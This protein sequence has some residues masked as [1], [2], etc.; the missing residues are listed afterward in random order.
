MIRM[1]TP[2]L[3]LIALGACSG[4]SLGID[5]LGNNMP[6]TPMAA[7]TPAPM[8][9]QPKLLTAKERLVGAIEDNGCELNATNVGTILTSATISREEL[10]QLTPQLSEEGRAEVSGSGAIRVM[11]DRC[12]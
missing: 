10:L 9:T 2:T 12:I 5:R 6:A 11:T 1:M 3:A 7:A 4:N 8:T